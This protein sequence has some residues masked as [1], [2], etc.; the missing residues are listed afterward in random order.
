MHF[1]YTA[2]GGN[3]GVDDVQQGRSQFAGQT[4]PPL[5]SD[6][7]TTYIKLFL[8]GLC[9]DVNPS[10]ALSNLSI[11]QVADIYHAVTT[12]WSQVPGSN[13]TTTIDPFGRDTNGGTYNFFLQGGAQ[14]QAPSSNV[15]ALT[16]DG[17]VANAVE[18]NPNA[19]GYVGLATGRTARRQA[20][21]LNGVA[22]PARRTSRRS[23][24]R[25][26]A[27]SGSCCRRTTRTRAVQRFA[28]WVRTSPTPARSSRR[29]AACR[30]S[31]DQQEEE[32]AT[33]ATEA[34]L[35]D[36]RRNTSPRNRFRGRPTSAPSF[37][38]ARWSSPSS[39]LLSWR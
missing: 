4:R 6:A 31:T 26:R 38:S 36:S 14:R 8:D 24:T 35:L 39:V 37:C 5:P 13:L 1:L 12:N 19:I 29:R 21:K 11:P 33:V 32:V 16:T 34:Y 22:V 28:D 10:N 20:L 27:T 2:N 25:S 3:A 18:G 23:S 9:I 15:T 7:G 17:L 30:R